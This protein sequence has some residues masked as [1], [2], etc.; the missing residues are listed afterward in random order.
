MGKKVTR[1]KNEAGSFIK[2]VKAKFKPSKIILFGSR[3]RGTAWNYS[4]YDFIIISE[5]FEHMHWLDRISAIVRHW[6]SD[7]PIDVLPYTAKEFK[8]KEKES[9]LIREAVRTGVVV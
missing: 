2:T 5:S 3:A 6:D 9:S 4:D 1:V 7:K 8:R